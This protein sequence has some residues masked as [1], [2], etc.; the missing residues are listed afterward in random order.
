MKKWPWIIYSTIL[1]SIITH[2]IIDILS[3]KSSLFTYYT[4][5]I[6]FNKLYFIYFILNVFSLLINLFIPL[7]V[8]YYGFNLKYDLKF[9]KILFFL[10]IFSDLTGHYYDLQTIKASFSQS[11]NWGFITICFLTLPFAFSY[12][13]HYQYVFGKPASKKP[14]SAK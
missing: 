13:A 1:T 2:D 12:I 10:R 6:A 14:T 7:V 11:L 8:F 9:W 4:I 5:L 3:K